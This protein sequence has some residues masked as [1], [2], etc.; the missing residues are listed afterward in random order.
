MNIP[1]DLSKRQTDAVY[2]YKGPLLVLA[3]PGSGKTRVITYRV[4]YLIRNHNISPESILAVTFTNKA[5][6]EMINRLHDDEL[7]GETIG[8]EVWI[9]TF[10]ATCVRILR[11]YGTK[12]GL[13]PRFAI[14]D[15]SSQEELLTRF[16]HDSKSSIS[17]DRVWLVREFISDAK[18]RLANPTET[19]ESDRLNRINARNEM[20]NGAIDINIDDLLDVSRLYQEYLNN[21]DVMDF[22][23]LVSKTVRLLSECEDVRNE[24]QRKFQF[25]MVDEYQ[26]I[27]LAQYEFISYLCNPERNIMVVADDDQS[28][29]SWR[30]SDPTFID[31]FREQ[32]NA[33]TLQ[34]VD[35]YR[36]TQ[37]I[38][39]ASQSL[40]TKNPRIKKS[41]LIT[42][43][44][45]GEAIYYYK[46]DDVN[47]ELDLVKRL[48]R[49][50]IKEKYYSPGQ[51]AIFY[52]THRLADKL[53]QYLIENK[54]GIRRVRREGLANDASI[55][56]VIGY[57]RLICWGLAPDLDIALN[58]PDVVVDELTKQQ[59]GNI[60]EDN[61]LELLDLFRNIN[62]YED[63]SPLTRRRI[64]GFVNLLD[65]LKETLK[66][67]SAIKTIGKMLEILSSERNPY[68][69]DDL[70]AI[71]NP[72]T[73]G[74]LQQAVNVLYDSI[75]QKH[76]IKV[77]AYY[78]IDNYCA[79]GIIT[80]VLNSYFDL[81]DNTK[82]QFLPPDTNIKDNFDDNANIYIII[83]AMDI[84]PPR[85]SERS[86]IIGDLKSN[87]LVSLPAGQG[88]VVSTIALKLC[89]RLMSSYE[90][91]STEGLILYDLE[92]T[93]NKPKTAEVI[94]IA[95]KKMGTRRRGSD[96]D[97]I[98]HELVNP[99]K[100]IPSSIT[101][102][103][104]PKRI[105]K[106]ISE[107][108]KI[109]NDDLKD[110]PG[111]EE[112]LPRFLKFIGD[113]ILIGHNIID[114]DNK[115]L[116][117]YMSS[118][119][120]RPELP[121][122]SYDTLAVARKLFPMENYKLDALADKFGIPYDASEL[123]RALKD[124]DLTERVFRS[125][126]REELSRNE[127]KS[128]KELLPLVALGILEK[129]AVM[130]KENA[131]FNNA[132]IR[133]MKYKQGRSEAI[134]LL[135]ISHLNPDE[136]E[137]AIRFLDRMSEEDPPETRENE[138]WNIMVSKIMNNIVNFDKSDYDKSITAFLSHAAL[139]TG[140]DVSEE[141]EDKVTM[142]TVHSAKGT[143]FPVVIMIGME[144]GSFPI[145]SPD[146]SEAELEEERRL[147]YV[148][149]TRAKRR[150][151]MTSVRF[152][153]SDNEVSPSQFIWE[154]QPDLIK[155]VTSKELQNARTKRTKTVRN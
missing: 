110:K 40:I 51:I 147:C 69:S 127:R 26:D 133:Y 138:T 43:N 17:M 97:T 24:L 65:E 116:S 82:C 155:T 81:E 42:N 135:P 75:Q 68:H 59:L 32:Y 61:K 18:V 134:G 76:I 105:S 107:I 89:Q 143:E 87:C 101:D 124:V 85:I 120:R 27:N 80:Y 109:T 70:S 55:K 53:E 62:S 95:A 5:A 128:L 137:E 35:H 3:G 151:Y 52:R 154:I 131:A 10:H 13:N 15:Q 12:I 108:T 150:L 86:I 63:I 71:E 130:E 99:R 22:D 47:E 100:S 14:L 78:G 6:Q 33:K 25:I 48:I 132:S 60:A 126:R 136:A 30:G 94:E 113:S 56:A 152:R 57:L 88:G 121:N 122:R 1:R 2:H 19:R 44:E 72:P 39:R 45:R 29:Y 73:F 93:G 46:L 34:L 83:G 74:D 119:M 114:F 37:T 28:I 90:V 16:I 31:K 98:F 144:Q 38:L 11:Q 140:S 49:Q 115:V 129:N 8:M 139:L 103:A 54:I 92:T 145:I 36:S 146:Q 149:I 104:N 112:V 125:L 102:L 141:N 123:H 79:A 20:S 117:K 153:M 23:D 77:I 41:S 111:I 9:H 118:F 106:T 7:L 96:Q 66:E 64:E 21:H 148:G 142:M 50:L 58:F 84:V 67:V 91:G 4:A